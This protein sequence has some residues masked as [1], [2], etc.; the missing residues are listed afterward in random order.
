MSTV[1]I[2]GATISVLPDHVR[3][4]TTHDPDE[5]AGRTCIVHSPTEHSM[6]GMRLHWRAD[7]GIF[8]RTC[9][10]RI[11]HPD[12]D[13]QAYWRALAASGMH[14]L[15]GEPPEPVTPDDWVS[16]QMTHGCDGCC[17]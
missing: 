16:A 5:C 8:E 2:D 10:H 15:D 1:L 4:M 7:R 6:R 9:E 3:V 17:A 12:P 13:Q 11:G 14:G